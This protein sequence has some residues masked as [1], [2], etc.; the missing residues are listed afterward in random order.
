MRIFIR[1]SLNYIIVFISLNESQPGCQNRSLSGVFRLCKS[2][3]AGLVPLICIRCD[4]SSLFNVVCHNYKAR[5]LWNDRVPR[6]RP[7]R[8]TTFA[9]VSS[10]EKAPRNNFDRSVIENRRFEVSFFWSLSLPEQSAQSKI[11]FHDYLFSIDF[12]LSFFM[13]LIGCGIKCTSISG[14]HI[15]TSDRCDKSREIKALCHILASLSGLILRFCLT[16]LA[17][18]ID[19]AAP[20]D[21]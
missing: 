9:F 7:A 5:D 2:D 19:V 1:R 3:V 8:R 20:R 12:H 16:Q 14:L 10:L 21:T 17:P 6:N 11:K 4:E 18:L 13:N 15:S